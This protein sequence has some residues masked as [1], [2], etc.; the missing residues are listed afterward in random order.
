MTFQSQ[1]RV[2]SKT[3]L[4][5]DDC[6]LHRTIHTQ[7]DR[8]ILQQDLHHLELWELT[9]G[10]EF[11]PGKCNSMSITRSR[12]SIENRYSLKGHI[13]EDVTESKYLGVTLSSNLTWNIHICNIT[14]KA[15]KL[16][17][18]L[19]RRNLKVKKWNNKGERIQSDNKIK[20]RILLYGM[21]T[22]YQKRT[23]MNWKEYRGE[24]LALNLV[25][26]TITQA[27]YPT[28]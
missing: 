16:L 7:Q 6:I 17:G 9:W 23:K 21:V 2:A 4:F 13:L 18:F 1:S 10:M 27:A 3:R 22:T 26:D 25:G 11:H 20:L 28:W 24:Q 19:R 12:T 8:D 14:G 15:N 5:A